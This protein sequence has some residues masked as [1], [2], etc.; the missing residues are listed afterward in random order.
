MKVIFI[1]SPEKWGASKVSKHHYAELLAQ[2]GSTVYFFQPPSTKKSLDQIKENLF[3][4][5]YKKIKGINKLPFFLK[6]FYYKIL[7]KQLRN[8]FGLPLPTLVWSFDPYTFQ[9]LNVFNK[10]AQKIYH[11]VDVH[12][13]NLEFESA[14]NADVVLATSDLILEKFKSIDK[15]QYQI[16]HGLADHFL[17]DLQLNKL[18][19]GDSNKIKVGYMGNLNYPFMDYT[20]LF[21]IIKENKKVDFYFIGPDGS[22]NLLETPEYLEEIDQIKK[23]DNVFLLGVKPSSELPGYL[24]S[25][26]AFLMCYKAEKNKAHMANPHKILEYLSTGKV[27]ISH[28]IDQYKNTDGLVE[29][30]EKNI[31]LPNKFQTV[32]NSLAQFNEVK[33]M[34]FRKAYAWNNTYENQLVKIDH[35]LDD[36]KQEV[37]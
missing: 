27:I 11:P 25:M 1:I 15:P 31:D 14:R 5:S 37:K 20:T 28:Y 2:K 3:L 12:Q 9:D 17:S 30:V 21:K 10:Q 13:T 4:V 36:L 26:D 7:F 23:M 22:S 35:I 18:L 8:E 33:K 32:V 19:P 24:N 16:N 34:E 6:Q 29:M